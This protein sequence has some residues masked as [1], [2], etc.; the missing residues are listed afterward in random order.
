MIAFT[1]AVF[2]NAAQFS[3]FFKKIAWREIINNDFAF[4]GNGTLV[5]AFSAAA[6]KRI[7]TLPPL[8]VFGKN[9]SRYIKHFCK[10][11]PGAYLAVSVKRACLKPLVSA[12]L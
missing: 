11:A 9:A 7:P 5:A 1:E 4:S 2:K 3:F 10:T 8:P 12:T 6:A